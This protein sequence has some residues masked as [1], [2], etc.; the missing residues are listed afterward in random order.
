MRAEQVQELRKSE[1]D[2]AAPGR[3]EGKGRWLLVPTSPQYSLMIALGQAAWAVFILLIPQCPTALCSSV[4]P[5]CIRLP[6]CLT[7]FW[8]SNTF[9]VVA[10]GKLRS[11]SPALLCLSAL[12]LILHSCGYSISLFQSLIFQM[13][14]WI[15][16]FFPNFLHFPS[17]FTMLTDLFLFLLLLSQ[18]IFIRL[19]DTTKTPLGSTTILKNKARDVSSH[20]F[21]MTL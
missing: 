6:Q 18:P 21:M 16:F 2:P 5:Q 20:V 1:L 8:G 4:L 3:W 14:A 15:M 13:F 11:F 17:P 9:R 12:H 7:S 19:K 10:P